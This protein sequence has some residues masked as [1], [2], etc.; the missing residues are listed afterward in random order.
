MNNFYICT[1]Y[2]NIST[3]EYAL[4]WRTNKAIKTIKTYSTWLVI[5]DNSFNYIHTPL[6]PPL[7]CTH[8]I[9][10]HNNTFL[11]TEIYRTYVLYGYV[12]YDSI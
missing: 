9:S 3:S 2:R 7:I 12:Q 5:F 4:Y 8:S 11:L 1:P 10:T 6:Q